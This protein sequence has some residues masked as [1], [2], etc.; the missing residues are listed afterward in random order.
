METVLGCVRKDLPNFSEVWLLSDNSA[1]V[2]NNF[3]PVIAPFIAQGA[4]LILKVIVHSD[5]QRGKRLVNAHVAFAMKQV[6]RFV[7][8][9]TWNVTMRGDLVTALQHRGGIKNSTAELVDDR[10][11]VS[12]M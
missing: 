5:T 11:H 1:C 2:Q 8:D 3:L 12:M 6:N 10:G 7:N 4:G 9:T